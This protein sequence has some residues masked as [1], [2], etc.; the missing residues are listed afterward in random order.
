[1]KYDKNNI[2]AKIIRNEIDCDKIYEDDYVIA[3]NDISPAAPIHA[4]VIPKGEYISFND[5]IE[6]ASGKEITNFWSSVNQVVKSLDIINNGYRII[7]NS[8]KNA[9]QTVEHFHVHILAGKPLGG[10]IA[11]DTNFFSKAN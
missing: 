11:S 6:N 1:M 9:S 2:F 3:F 10:L 4:L 8:G 5:F 7:A